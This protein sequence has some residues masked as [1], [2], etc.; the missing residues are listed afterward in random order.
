MGLEISIR[1]SDDVTIVDLRGHSTV[2]DGESELLSTRLQDLIAK[3]VRKVL[4]NL[5]ELAQI[6]SSGVSIF[7]ETYVSLKRRGGSLKLLCS[8]SRV[9]EVLT[10]FHLQDIIPRFE[11]EAHALASFQPQVAQA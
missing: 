9:L 3:G 7:V 11:D 4:L 1:K 5:R 2:K 6:D 10:A 8:R